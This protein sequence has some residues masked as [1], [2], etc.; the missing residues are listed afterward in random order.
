MTLNSF[1]LYQSMH[2]LSL[3][4][5]I[6]KIAAE[7]ANKAGAKRVATIFLK[8]GKLSGAEPESLRNA[9]SIAAEQSLLAG[10][11]LSIEEV[12]VTI[13]CSTCQDPQRVE[14]IQCMMC[15]VCGTPG[16]DVVSGRE[17]DIVA[18]EIEQDETRDAAG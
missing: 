8:L 3:A 11:E 5:N 7:E 4:L 18:L 10:C 6:L 17:L 1:W 12:P 14:S 2:E 13:Q 9:F 15:S 16:S